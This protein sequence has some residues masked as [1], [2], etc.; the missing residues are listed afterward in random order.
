MRPSGAKYVAWC[1][2]SALALPLSAISGVL[3]SVPMSLFIIH[4]FLFCF[5]FYF[6]K[7]C[8]EFD[9]GIVHE[10]ISSDNEVLPLFEGKVICKIERA[11]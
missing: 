2:T 10:E 11:N 5:R 6:K 9:S 3:R 8:D 4:R 7:V 1:D